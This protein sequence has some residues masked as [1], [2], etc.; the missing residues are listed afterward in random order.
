MPVADAVSWQAVAI[1]LGGSFIVAVLALVGTLIAS[2][3]QALT[4]CGQTTP[5]REAGADL[6]Q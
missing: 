3:R 6:R 4:T 1:S 5:L 2:R